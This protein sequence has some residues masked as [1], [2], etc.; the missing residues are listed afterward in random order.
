[1]V[2][3]TISAAN[4]YLVADFRPAASASALRLRGAE[5]LT[6]RPAEAAFLRP[7][8]LDGLEPATGTA[9]AFARPPCFFERFPT[10]FFDI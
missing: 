3:T 4:T 5:G 2:A 1:M 6:V 10:F 7:A 8:W 9:G